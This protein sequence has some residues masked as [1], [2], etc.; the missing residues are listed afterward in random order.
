MELHHQATSVGMVELELILGPALRIG[1]RLI[2]A[3]GE[4]VAE[5]PTFRSAFKHRRCLVPATGFYE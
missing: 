5:K 3:Q 2:N 1:N 4:S